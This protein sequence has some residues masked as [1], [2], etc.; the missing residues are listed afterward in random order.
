MRRPQYEI[1]QEVLTFL[2][3]LGVG[4]GNGRDLAFFDTF[5]P[6]FPDSEKILGLFDAALILAKPEERNEKRLPAVR[7]GGIFALRGVFDIPNIEMRLTMNEDFL[8]VEDV[9]N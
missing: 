6:P 1:F 7:T 5:L 2:I 8:F 4:D 9:C 3:Y